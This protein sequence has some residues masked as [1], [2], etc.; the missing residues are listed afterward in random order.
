MPAISV[1]I[2]CA[3]SANTL[4]AACSS[5]AWADELIVVDS[6]SEDDTPA[7]ARQHAHRYIVEPWRG[8]SGQKHFASGLASH[9]WIFFLDGD[10]ECSPELA[11]QWRAI[12]DEQAAKYDLLLVPRVNYVMGRV[13]RAWW[14][15]H[16]TR[17]FHRG[18]CSWD[19]HVLHDT[20]QA[21]DPSRVKKLTGWLVHKRL[22]DAGFSDYFSGQRLDERLLP[23]AR[24]MHQRGK[25]CHWWDLLLRPWGAFI[26]FYFIKR[27][28]LDGTFG[29]LIA[30]KAAVSTQLKYAALWAVQDEKRR[31]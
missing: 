30:Q 13:V 21:S 11:A 1:I 19:G 3:N 8:H 9:D 18:R 14:P 12:S 5:V 7:V 25:R 2:C 20:R 31:S 27:G 4:T 28:F 29:L 24:Q 17:I 10:E 16:L 15:D 26:K 22:S 6:G 23:V